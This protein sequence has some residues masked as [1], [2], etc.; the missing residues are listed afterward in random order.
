MFKALCNPVKKSRSAKPKA[1]RT[2]RLTLEALEAREVPS[3]THIGVVRPTASGVAQFSLDNLG[4]GQFGPGDSVFSFGL[5]SDHFLV[6]DWNGS[7]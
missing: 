2:T 4:N 5:N 7:G 1:R 3:A 6:G